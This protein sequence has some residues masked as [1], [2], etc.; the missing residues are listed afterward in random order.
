MNKLIAVVIIALILASCT[1]ET[2]TIRYYKLSGKLSL[3]D[4]SPAPKNKAD[5]PLV[6]IEPIILAEFLRRKGLVIQKNEYQIQISNIH[7]WA[8]ELDR[9]TARLIRQELEKSLV[10]FRVEDQSGR[11]KVKPSYRVSIELNQFQVNHKSQTVTSGQFWIF[12][13]NREILAKKHFSFE[14]DLKVDGYEHAISQLE[15]SLEQLSQLITSEMR[16]NVESK[17]TVDSNTD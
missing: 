16:K 15:F 10:D 3:Q 2:A 9:A 11:W 14:L 1:N 8:E 13:K 7:R 17:K 6:L 5:Q 4:Q 12:G